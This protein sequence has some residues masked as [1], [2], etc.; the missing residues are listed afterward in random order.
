MCCKLVGREGTAMTPAPPPASPSLLSCTPARHTQIHRHTPSYKFLTHLATS[1][2][3]RGMG[4]PPRTWEYQCNLCR[5]PQCLQGVLLFFTQRGRDL[6]KKTNLCYPI[7]ALTPPFW[8]RASLSLHFCLRDCVETWDSPGS[9]SWFR[10]LLEVRE[11]AEF[12]PEGHLCLLPY[13]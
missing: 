13:T 1:T 8:K 12:M 7:L 10:N 3:P 4:S 9:W 6:R 5:P 2:Y 11:M